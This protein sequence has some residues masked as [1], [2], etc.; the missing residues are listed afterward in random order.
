MGRGYALWPCFVGGHSIGHDQAHGDMLFMLILML[1]PIVAMI[2]MIM[3]TEG[4]VLKV[5][6]KK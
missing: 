3:I 1:M 6:R 2:M 4:F 5:I